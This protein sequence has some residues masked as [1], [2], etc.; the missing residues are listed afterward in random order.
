MVYLWAA[1]GGW[2]ICGENSRK[3]GQEGGGLSHVGLADVL[4]PR[5]V[6]ALPFLSRD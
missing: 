5:P 1:V 2:F 6:P 3:C 4:I